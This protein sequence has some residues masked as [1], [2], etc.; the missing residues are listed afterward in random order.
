MN[1]PARWEELRRHDARA[2]RRA[3]EQFDRPLVLE[4]GAGTGK[5][6]ALVCRVVV[7]CMG[8]GWERSLE[9]LAASPGGAAPETVAARVLQRVVAITFTDAA[10]AKM[11]E[12]IASALL[13]VESGTLPVWL[14]AAALPDDLAER[15]LRARALRGALDHLAAQTIHAWCRRL[16]VASPLEARLHPRLEIDADQRRQAEIVREVLEDRLAAAYASPG[17]AELELAARGQGPRELEL[18]LLALLEAGLAAADLSS[19]P[20][21]ADRLEALR[22]RVVERLEGFFAAGGGGLREAARARKSVAV[23][24]A[25]EQLRERVHAAPWHDAAVLGAFVAGLDDVL[26]RKLGERLA[27]W[28]SDRF[29]RGEQAVLGPE[30]EE[31]VREAGAL[32]PLL[33]HLRG[34]APEPLD[35][36]RRVLLP[37]LEEVEGRMRARGVITF[38][39]LLS[40]AQQLLRSHREVAARVRGGI[41]QLLVDE[42]QDTDRR[43]CDIVRALALAG[44]EAS[45]PGLFVVGD[46]KQSIYG[47]RSA[48]LAAYDA[49]VHDVIAA[50]GSLERLSVNFRSVP[51]VLDEVERAI[52][53]VMKQEAGLQP[54]FQPLAPSAA[55]EGDPGH[56]AGGRAAI[57]YWASSVWDAEA[58]AAAGTRAAEGSRLEA[59]ALARDLLSLHDAGVAWSSIG[60]LFRGRA[61]FEVYLSELR[62]ARVPYAVEGDRSYYRRREVIEAAALVRC[63]LDPNDHLAL[64]AVLRSAL[65]GVPDAALLPL[66]ERGFAG[67][68]GKLDSPGP[69]VDALA[70]LLAEVA[71]SLPSVP[72]LERVQGWE[73]NAQAFC[74]AVAHL[75]VSFREDP[76]DRFVETLRGL[77]LFE[78]TEAARYLGAWRLANLDRF[79]RDLAEEL[80]E[81]CDAFSVLRRLRRAV[82]EEEGREEGVPQ[83]L[84]EDAVQILTIHGAKGLDFAHVYVMQL[85]KGAGR[86]P[87]PGIDPGEH[88]G[89]LEYRLFGRPTPAW[90]RV[91]HDRERMEVAE[92]VRTLYV[93]MTRAERRLVMAGVWPTLQRTSRRDQAIALLQERSD[94][95][96]D[97]AALMAELAAAGEH[98]RDAC[99]TRWVF[100]ALAERERA[101]SVARRPGD[102][103]LPSTAAR[104]RASAALVEHRREA[105]ARELRRYGGAASSAAH[106]DRLGDAAERRFGARGE[107]FA[108]GAIG[109]RA[110]AI[111]GRADAISRAVG[112]VLHRVLEVFDPSADLARELARHEALLPG[113]VDAVA[114]ASLREDVLREASSLLTGLA[115]G[116]LLDRL[117]RLAGAIVARELPVLRP[118]AADRGP[119]GFV[120]GVADLVYR[121]PGSGRLVVVDYKTDRVAG[122]AEVEERS[123]AY[124]AQGAV[125]QEAL[126]DGLGL[127]YTPRFELWYLRADLVYAP[128]ATAAP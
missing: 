42:F 9:A 99:A 34:L 16:L 17:S 53:P 76:A 123:A 85:H 69:E 25:L 60:V 70:A 57:E 45:R 94:G 22:L 20:L 63:V 35:L 64:A 23:V 105:A 74:E 75:R 43:Q 127:D 108:R 101:A 3:R 46:P 126:R 107:R 82:S 54:A 11:G 65:V 44:P 87:R 103:G 58:G 21:A 2:R 121:D 109:G 52:E 66:W 55:H 77:T 93:A 91:S 24:E 72:G 81:E 32:A 40:G 59:R 26:P 78:A 33:T 125:Y 27:D 14:P 111:G 50:G 56:C 36:A 31:L 28:A 68:L 115:G 18:E 120:S 114:E 7:W 89:R 128:P 48:D 97:L 122:R 37:L 118:A 106:E 38:S 5:T 124:L 113:L 41:D 98:A 100:P 112:S 15:A 10:A 104:A 83:D 84:A 88:D 19:D 80:A 39:A 95:V 62:A 86:A 117:R 51:A 110:D 67:A 4:A 61:D 92:R 13:Q 29:G 102:D 119:V 79:F 30:R 73:R 90:D 96:P 116:T 1:A 8:A 12:E 71:A 6:T 49:F 47:W